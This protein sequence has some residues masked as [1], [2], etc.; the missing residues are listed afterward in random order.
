MRLRNV[1][2]KEEIM[3]NSKYLVKNYFDYK[4]KWSELF[5]NNNPIYIEIGMG[6]GKF[7]I[8]NAVMYPD[9]NF[10]GIEKFDSVICKGLQK[11]PDGLNNLI[12]IRAD[13]L[14]ID[15]IFDKE[16]DRIYLNFSDPWPKNRHHL[17]RLS[18]KVFLNKYAS[19][20]K[21]DAPI[22]M[23]TDNRGL[24]QYSL[25]S[26]SENGYIL[27]DLSLDLHKDDMPL[28]TTEYEDKFSNLDMPIYFVECTKDMS[29]SRK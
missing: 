4:G 21:N 12:M 10:I 6:K 28:I 26:F 18:S 23:R 9:I 27:R 11:I 14:D 16:I 3:N 24:F 1:K 20:F 19:L 2:N 22:F 7:I 29:K 25:V 5:G 17:R 13:A 15:N 8:E